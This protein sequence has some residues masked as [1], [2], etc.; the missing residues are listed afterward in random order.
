MGTKGRSASSPQIIAIVLALFSGAAR[1]AHARDFD[2]GADH[3]KSASS[4]SWL[5][6]F[7]VLLGR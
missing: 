3:A 7:C 6:Q 4:R 1:V 2:L 5:D